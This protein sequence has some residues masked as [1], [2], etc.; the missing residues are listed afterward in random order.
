MTREELCVKFCEGLPE[1]SLSAAVN[2]GVTAS[3]IWDQRDRAFR[4]LAVHRIDIYD[5]SME[6]SDGGLSKM[7]VN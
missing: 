3:M 6:V 2:S 5:D 1:G 7:A 4:N